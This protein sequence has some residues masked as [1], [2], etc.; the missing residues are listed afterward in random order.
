M[1][2]LDDDSHGELLGRAKAGDA[3]ALAALIE[4]VG[5]ELRPRCLRRR[6]IP[7]QLAAKVAPSDLVQETLLAAARQ[8]DKFRGVTVAEFWAWVCRI[9]AHRAQTAR[10]DA[11]RQ[12][13]DAGREVT[14]DRAGSVPDRRRPGP[15]AELEAR[16]A[17]A[18][19][20]RALAALSA[21]DR[22]ILAMRW[23]GSLRFDDIARILGVTAE[24]ARARHTR[25]FKN[26][27][28]R[29]ADLGGH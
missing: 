2:P 5:P 26:L 16:E 15:A 7:P 23:D 9:L 11:A 10:R 1:P 21:G 17:G 28:D 3:A 6:L 22:Q 8:F 19:R 29:V 4:A 20:D 12:R 27:K 14:L 18:I 25:A 24:A 13:R